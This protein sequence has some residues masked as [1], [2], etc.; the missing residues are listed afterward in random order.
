MSDPVLELLNKNNLNFTVSGRDYLIKCLNP[1]HEDTNPSF[2]VDRFSGVAHCFSCGFKTNI[3][4]YF[5]IFTNPVPLRIMN[6]K[7][8]LKQLQVSRE[9]ELP[10]GYTPWTKPFR[11][12]SVQTLKHFE[13]FYTNQ[14]EKL[15][16]R[17]V[18]PITD[19]TNK[20]QVFVGRHTL[21]N[22]NPKYLNYPSGVEMPLYPSYLQE[23]QK[24]IVLV[25]GIFDMLNLYDKG[26]KNS[27]CCFG[28]NTIQNS[29]KEKLLPFKAQ[30]VTHVYILFDGDEAGEKAAKQLKPV[31]EQDEFIVEIIKLPDGL[32]PGELD[33]IDVTSIKEYTTK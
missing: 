31:L 10:Q 2:R 12:I 15:Q 28:T 25:E 6:L 33:Q 22:G 8:K 18:F 16:D 19:I 7:K 1:D 5:G 17:I 30:G 9:Q 13:A 27:V 29:T 21:S 23:P 11:G 14:V 26:L 24:S 32:D 20:I 3:F 4:K